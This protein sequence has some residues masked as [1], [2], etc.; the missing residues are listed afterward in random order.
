MENE[1]DCEVYAMWLIRGGRMVEL[2]GAA[3]MEFAPELP[4][5]RS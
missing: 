3:W 2:S 5:P 4:V 1:L